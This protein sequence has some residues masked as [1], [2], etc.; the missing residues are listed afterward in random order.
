MGALFYL[1]VRSLDR[2]ASADKY[3]RTVAHAVAL[4]S[5]S[6]LLSGTVSAP[7]SHKTKTH[8]SKGHGVHASGNVDDPQN[9]DREK[10]NDEVGYY[11][12]S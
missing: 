8:Q 1:H 12:I 11:S 2:F 9:N 6:Q 3:A 7:D 10:R 4:D 5:K